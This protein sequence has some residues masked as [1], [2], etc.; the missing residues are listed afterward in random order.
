MDNLHGF[1]SAVAVRDGYCLYNGRTDPYPAC[2]C[3]DLRAGA[4]HSRAEV[5]GHEI[6]FVREPY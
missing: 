1:D 6:K 4:R 5:L 3:P 2:S